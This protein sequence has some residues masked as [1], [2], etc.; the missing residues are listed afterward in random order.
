MFL[1]DHQK[2]VL[3]PS[4]FPGKVH[5]HMC[6]RRE[7]LCL[8]HRR[9]NVSPASNRYFPFFKRLQDTWW[10]NLRFVFTAQWKKKKKKKKPFLVIIVV[11]TFF[12]LL[13]HQFYNLFGFLNALCRGQF[14]SFPPFLASGVRKE[15]KKDLGRERAIIALHGAE[16]REGVLIPFARS[17]AARG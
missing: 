9:R 16:R 3:S 12:A 5:T 10:S 8:L 14:K 7:K 17:D 6:F 11:V 1:N 15:H 4:I 2:N 13:R